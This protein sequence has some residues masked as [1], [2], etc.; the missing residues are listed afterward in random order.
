MVSI[1]HCQQDLQNY[2]QN[3]QQLHYTYQ[4]GN[5]DLSTATRHKL[6]VGCPGNVV[7]QQL[8][9]TECSVTYAFMTL[10]TLATF[11]DTWYFQLSE[12]KNDTWFHP[13]FTAIKG[14]LNL[15]QHH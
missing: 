13:F 4:S 8:R 11:G 14:L 3:D 5:K 2:K 9:V 15:I 6:K 7:K 12:P 1:E 10:I